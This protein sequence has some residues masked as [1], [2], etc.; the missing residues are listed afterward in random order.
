[1]TA[2]FIPLTLVLVGVVLRGSAFIFRKY[3]MHDDRPFRRWSTV[4][5]VSSFLTPFF[6]GLC[7]GALGTGDLQVVDGVPVNGFFAGWTT[8]FAFGCGIFAL[9]LFAFVSAVYLAADTHRYP[10]LQA[11]FRYRALVSGVLLA[12]IA[13]MVF[14]LSRQ[15][16]TEIY[17]DLTSW[18]GPLL[19]LV[20]S[21]FAVGALWAVWQRRFT[22]AR[23]AVAGQVACILL[24]WGFAQFP[25]LV[26]PDLTI[27]SA[28]APP[29]TLRFLI[30]GLGLGALI[31]FPSLWYLL[32]VF[33]GRGDPLKI[34]DYDNS[35]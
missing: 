22:L 20:T 7:L 11:D 25:Y 14:V 24:G 12:P 19:L 23:F 5:G 1:M 4:F 6:L 32:R 8:P 21:V 16:S 27:S 31:L 13:V 26:V 2:L 35:L 30:I 15:G 10:D 29:V 9:G 33:K 17:N 28:A 34:G 18:W 3:S